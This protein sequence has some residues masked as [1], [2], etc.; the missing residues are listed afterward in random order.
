MNKQKPLVK[1]KREK[2][3]LK[4]LWIDDFEKMLTDLGEKRYKARQLAS[5]I[6]AKGATDFSQMT[7]L[8]Q[9]LRR[10]LADI[11]YIDGV[12]LV[13]RQISAKDLSEKFLFELAD[14]QKI[15]TVLMWE[16]RRVTVCL[17][18]QV[19]CP[20]GCTF[21][22]T[23]QMGFKRNLT[24]GEIVDQ[25]IALR[26]YP[27]THA[28]L[29]GMG[30]PLLN[31]DATLRAI[32]IL[33]DEMGL[34]FSGKRITLSTAGIPSAIKKLAEERRKIKLAIS[35]NAPTDA[36]R[37]EIMPVNK[38]HPLPDL[39]AAV[40]HFTDETNRGVTFE[41]VLI[42]DVND[43]EKDAL[44]LSKLVRGIQCKINLIPYNAL[45]DLPY[46]RPSEEKVVAFRD[47][48]YPRCPAVTL[49]ISK[50]EDILAACGQLR[51]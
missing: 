44:A 17:S 30:E 1:Q 48:L 50:G 14:G 23:G 35:L 13:K 31:F 51:A 7:D 46:R 28:V 3:N 42:E 24:A 15:E 9:D 34:S 6:Y 2:V 40:K 12:K 25:A 41:Y 19:G 29:M 22:A 38:K 8:S 21:C 47:Y 11:S 26:E 49:R 37:S 10:K 43:S 18:T 45:P 5:W 27:L 39:M 16:G 32:R 4:G 36:K 33:N 20:L